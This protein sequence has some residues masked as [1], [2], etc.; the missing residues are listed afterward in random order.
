MK[1]VAEKKEKIMSE[2]ILEE[3][4]KAG[5]HF[6]HQKARWHPKM[7][8][9]IFTSKNGIN[10]IDLE[11]TAEKLKQAVDFVKK[12]APEGKTVLFIGTKRQA[13]EIIKKYAE[14]SGMPYVINRWLGGTFTNFTVIHKVINKFKELKE[15]KKKGELEKYTKRERMLLDEEIMRLDKLVGGIES[16]RKL[17]E[18]IYVVDVKQE[19][20]ALREAKRMKIPI[21]AMIDTNSNP[22]GIKYPIPA[23]DDATKSIEFVTAKIAEAVKDGQNQIKEKGE[24]KKKDENNK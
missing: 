23:N 11:K 24:E 8:P 3:M 14:E 2:I 16:L 22:E 17:P 9:F 18:A 20:T 1:R 21:V 5:I 7:E 13:Q 4:L 10:I 12:L 6:G 15:Q 19:R